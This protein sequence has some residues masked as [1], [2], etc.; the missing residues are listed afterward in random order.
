[1]LMPPY[2]A[3]KLASRLEP[4]EY[5]TAT[6]QHRG[7]ETKSRH[8][9]GYLVFEASFGNLGDFLC[10]SGVGDGHRQLVNIDG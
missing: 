5:G 1:M 4:P 3:E 7:G 2:G 6:C 8:T 10:R 9:H